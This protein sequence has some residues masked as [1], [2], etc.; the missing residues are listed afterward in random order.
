MSIFYENFYPNLNFEA[1]EKPNEA[2][3]SERNT[4]FLRYW[5]IAIMVL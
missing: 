4:N 2:L 3:E 5:T 1:S